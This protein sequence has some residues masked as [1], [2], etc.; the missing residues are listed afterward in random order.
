MNEEGQTEP[1][2]LMGLHAIKSIINDDTFS[3]D[4]PKG[5]DCNQN[6]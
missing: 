5:M 4:Q 1:V 3:I 6:G 2:H